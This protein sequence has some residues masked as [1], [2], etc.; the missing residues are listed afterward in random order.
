[1][2]VVADYGVTDDFAGCGLH[3]CYLR[4]FLGGYVSVHMYVR[5]PF[6]VGSLR[7][8]GIQGI[9]LFYCISWSRCVNVLYC[10]KEDLCCSTLRFTCFARMHCFSISLLHCSDSMVLCLLENKLLG[11]LSDL[12]VFS[13]GLR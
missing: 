2:G 3:F 9:V 1:V 8:D 11:G 7:F 12:C 10:P 13:L 6:L 5:F 4:I